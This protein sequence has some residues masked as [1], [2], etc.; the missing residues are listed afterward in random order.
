MIGVGGLEKNNFMNHVCQKGVKGQRSL[1]LSRDVEQF[2]TELACLPL[3]KMFLD[4]S[5]LEL[6]VPALPTPS[7]CERHVSKGHECH[8]W[9]EVIKIRAS[10]A[11]S[12]LTSNELY[13]KS[14]EALGSSRINTEKKTGFLL[15]FMEKSSQQIQCTMLDR[16]AN[17]K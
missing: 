15:H 11:F 1:L 9:T 7:P 4:I 10:R 13:S 14:L 17:K 2:S 6:L 5:L 16:Y 3:F 8:F 12:L